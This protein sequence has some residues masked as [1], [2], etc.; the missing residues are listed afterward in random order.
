MDKTLAI[1]LLMIAVQARALGPALKP[2]GI[3][4]LPHVEGR[5]DHLAA[6]T[7][8]GRLYVAA[9]GNNS[10]EVV[11][12]RNRAVIHSIT[13]LDEPQGCLLLPGNRLAVTGGGDG[14]VR[15]FSDSTFQ[16]LQQY[17]LRDDA[18]N[19]RLSP[20][21]SEIVVG[22]GTGAVAMIDATTL[23]LKGEIVLAGHPESFQME[24]GSKTVYIND[25]ATAQVLVGNGETGNVMGRIPLKE[26]GGNF[27]MALDESHH[28]LF[29][30]CRT[31]A[32]LMVIDTETGKVAGSAEIHRDADDVYYDDVNDC[33]YVSCGEG[34]LDVLR[35]EAGK[36]VRV[37]DVPTFKGART[38][39]FQ[40]R[41][42]MLYVAAPRQG[43][44][45]ACIEIFS[46]R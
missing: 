16:Q 26:A 31:P 24:R 35:E 18:D 9:L 2:A 23:E 42:G 36:V 3:V 27:P 38:C 37:M 22:Y 44:R 14:T 40:P 28:R 15:I 25:P 12:V 43:K 30:G 6:D 19:I 39:C 5:I 8:G 1:G 32:R 46:T 20:D 17:G 11:D 45:D 41:T 33:V 7:A 10:V 29:V 21:G 34:F 13:G 4:P